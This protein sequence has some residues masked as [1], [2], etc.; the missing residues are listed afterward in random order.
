MKLPSG[1]V[2]VTSFWGF[3]PEGEGY[4]G[5][6]H[7]GDRTW[8]LREW[9]RGD[10]AM[11]YAT[12]GDNTD[13]AERGRVMGFL[14]IEPKTIRD[15]AR[16]DAQGRQ[17][18]IDNRVT[19]RWTY[20]VPVVRAWRS[21]DTPDV[22]EIAPTT[23]GKGANWQLI[24]KRGVALL[25]EEAATALA[26]R[27]RPADVYGE[28][29]LSDEEKQRVYV[30]SRG[31]P[32]SFG[33]RVSETTD[34]AHFLYALQLDG[35]VTAIMGEPSHALRGKI[36]VKVGLAKNPD[37]RCEQ[38]NKCLP[39]AARMRWKLLL[40]SRPLPDGDTALSAENAMKRHFE[41]L[42]RS[43]GGEFFLCDEKTLGVEFAKVRSH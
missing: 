5:F 10:L 21:I 42:Y 33:K 12:M 20:A 40:R 8:F 43:L 24:S 25:P 7:E 13:E 9:R 6:T 29:L 26:M 37:E 28:A 17:W 31:F 35:D 18:K 41:D 16:T 11:V 30:P 3:R 23:L 22:R 36:I 19:G 1:R 32:M 38:H 14:E 27:V 15:T 39:P 34:G 2:W 4:L